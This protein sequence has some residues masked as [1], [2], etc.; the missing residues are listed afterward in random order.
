[1]IQSCWQVYEAAELAT[2]HSAYES[3]HGAVVVQ[4]CCTVVGVVPGV[5]NGP[6][7]SLL[8]VSALTHERVQCTL[9]GCC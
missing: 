1:M 5:T 8:A 7:L 4:S 6:L 3:A 2:V 9:I